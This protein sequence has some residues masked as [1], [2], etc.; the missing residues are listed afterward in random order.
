VSP[1]QDTARALLERHGRTF[2]DELGI[3]IARNTFAVLFRL[4]SASMLMS[5]RIR[6][7]TAVDAA[8]SLAKRGW[9]SPHKLAESTW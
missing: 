8:R 2:A 5:A 4:L 6:S 3:D 9:R 7:Q 1:R